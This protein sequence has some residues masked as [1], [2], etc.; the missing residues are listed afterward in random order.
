M[1]VENAFPQDTRVK[2]E[3]D[4]LTAAGYTVTVVALRKQG[5]LRSEMVDG[6]Q[7]Y[8]CHALSSLRKPRRSIPAGSS[9]SG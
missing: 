1:F 4:A 7:V 6:I 8:R 5:Q 9:G 2:N 3:A